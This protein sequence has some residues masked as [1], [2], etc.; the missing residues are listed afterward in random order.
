MKPSCTTPSSPPR[1]S[2]STSSKA[3]Q[4]ALSRRFADRHEDRFDGVGY[5]RSPEGL[6][7]L[8]GALAHLECDREA[9]YPGGD[10]TIIIGRVIG[11][12]DQ[13]RPA[14]AVLPRRLRGCWD[15]HRPSRHHP[16]RRQ[17]CSTTPRPTRRPSPCRCG[18]SRAPTAGS[19]APPRCGYGLARVL[20]RAC[21]RAAAHPARSRHRRR[22]PARARGPLGRGGSGIPSGPVGLELQPRP[23]PRW[24]G[25]PGV[26]CAVACAGAPPIRDKSVDLVLVSQVVHHLTAPRRCGCSAPVTASPASG[27]V[28]ADLR[29]GTAGADGVLGRRPAASRFDPSTVADGITSIRRG[30]TVSELRALLAEA[31]VSARVDRR[32][33]YRLVAT[34]RTPAPGC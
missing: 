7:L 12:G 24:R 30:Y 5:H 31:G 11:G 1:S 22:R 32:P 25:R 33:G 27:V 16:A 28:V 19:A 29:R 20:E 4:E 3:R 9:S 21:P 34:W 18:T 6:V 8:D 15:E 13:R 10:H 26:P 14:A 17:S 2:W 23:P